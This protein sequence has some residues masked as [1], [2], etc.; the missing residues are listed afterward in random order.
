MFTDQEPD[1]LH[2]SPARYVRSLAVFSETSQIH[3]KRTT[4]LTV[5][6]LD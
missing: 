4:Q 3:S 6:L 1:G 5:L 2:V